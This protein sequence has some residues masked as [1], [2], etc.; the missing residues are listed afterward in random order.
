MAFDVIPFEA[1]I[2]EDCI[3]QHGKPQERQQ[4]IDEPQQKSARQPHGVRSQ[5]IR[6]SGTHA[7]MHDWYASCRPINYCSTYVQA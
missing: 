6:T 1:Q 7:C 4:D 2:H 5:T 3:A